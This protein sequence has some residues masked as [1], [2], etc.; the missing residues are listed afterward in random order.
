[1]AVEDLDG[2]EEE[3]NFGMEVMQEI[4]QSENEN[5]ENV[6]EPE[7]EDTASNNEEADL[8]LPPSNLNER[9]TFLENENQQLNSYVKQLEANLATAKKVETSLREK[10]R[11]KSIQN[12]DSDSDISLTTEQPFANINLILTE[13]EQSNNQPRKSNRKNAIILM[14]EEETRI[15]DI[16]R[17]PDID[18]KTLGIVERHNITNKG[19]GIVATRDF[20]TGSFICEYSGILMDKVTALA[21]EDEYERDRKGC[22]IFFFVAG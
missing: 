20:K 14:Q 17:Q 12:N 10:L 11:Q 9:L 5:C 21:Q 15:T 6:A 7:N 18:E 4:G 3:I 13:P 8:D 2:Q 19:R 1:M 16:L 22:F